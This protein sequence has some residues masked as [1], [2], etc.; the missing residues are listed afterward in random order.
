MDCP[1]CQN[2]ITVVIR[3][4]YM[5]EMTCRSDHN[6]DGTWESFHY[7]KMIRGYSIGSGYYIE[8]AIIAPYKVTNHFVN[9]EV[10]KPYCI[11]DKLVTKYENPSPGLEHYKAWKGVITLPYTLEIKPYKKMQ[12]RLK[13]ILVF[14]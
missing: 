11:I 1:I 5:P 14:S 6:I 3:E 2:K 7:S 4:N 10:I 13:S 12:E 8:E 9:N